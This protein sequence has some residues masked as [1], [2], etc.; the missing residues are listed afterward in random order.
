MLTLPIQKD[1]ADYEPKVIGKLTKRTLVCSA[2][3]IGAS[4]LMAF[5]L[6]SVICVG[7][8]EWGWLV[9][10]AALPFW[11]IGFWKP[12][13]MRAEEWLPLWAKHALGKDVLIYQSAWKR[14]E[15]EKEVEDVRKKENGKDA[16]R[17]DRA[18]DAVFTGAGAERL[19]P[20]DL[21]G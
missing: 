5:Y 10:I 16:R 14:D 19:R 3:A 15:F 4:L 7:I 9:V 18:L 21:L 17:A 8:D 11:G 2:C 1:L 13:G 6:N 12:D 20:S